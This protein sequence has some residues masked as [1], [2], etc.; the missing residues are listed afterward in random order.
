MTYLAPLVVLPFTHRLDILCMALL[1]TRL[2]AFAAFFVA[3]YR[4]LPEV[5]SHP[6]IAWSGMR[7]LLSFSGWM[8]ITNIVGPLMTYL[9]RFVIGSA[10]SIVAVAYYTT[11]FEVV[12]R[13]FI[14][15]AA[16]TGVMFPAFAAMY[17]LKRDAARKLFLRGNKYL[18]IVM[19]PITL[20]FVTLA[21]PG[22][23]IW[24][25]QGFAERSTGVLQW[26]AV[27]VLINS[28]AQLSFVLVQG[29]GRPYLT[30]LLNLIELP[31]YLV[32][33]ISL[34]RG[35]GI[36]G[37]AIA[38]ALRIAIDAAVL[39]WLSLK[40]LDIH[41]SRLPATVA[42]AG[43]AVA[44]LV[45]GSLPMPVLVKLVFLAVTGIAMALVAWFVVLTG[46]ERIE[47]RRTILSIS[48]RI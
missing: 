9:D 18:A 14:I 47:S 34:V 4:V 31:I 41:I 27:G 42:V 35:A 33:L 3:C 19:F 2:V 23:N 25:G 10:I 38:W 32:L 40:L 30:G 46:E 11:P 13:L 48:N 6:A 39:L 5:M 26:L 1:A 21:S 15:P 16:L 36:E 45:I 29:A 24:L 44:L 22:L 37:A 43:L 7:S 20:A 12:T 8:A 28:L 17:G